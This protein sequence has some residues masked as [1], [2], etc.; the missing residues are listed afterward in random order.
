MS[1]LLDENT[2]VIVQGMTGREGSLRTAFMKDYGTQVVA[3]VTPGRSGQEVH[4]LP[5]YDTVLEAIDDSQDMAE[6]LLEGLGGK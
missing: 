6:S 3:G 2:S 1:I 5:V 4:G